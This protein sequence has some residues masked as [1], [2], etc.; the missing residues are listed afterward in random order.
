MHSDNSTE[1]VI[2][3]ITFYLTYEY[4]KLRSFNLYKFDIQADL[5]NT[6]E[7]VTSV[8]KAV[9]IVNVEDIETAAEEISE[10]ITHEAICDAAKESS[11]HHESSAAI[12]YQNDS[13]NN[14]YQ[15]N[16]EDYHNQDSDCEDIK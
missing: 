8:G 2:I 5:E 9:I 16:N 13:I 14:N 10:A 6:D 4:F 15:N 3:Y 7:V 12:D 11:L 1:P